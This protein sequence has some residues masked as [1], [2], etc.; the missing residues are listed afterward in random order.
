TV[1]AVTAELLGVSRRID[2]VFVQAAARAANRACAILLDEAHVISEWPEEVQEALNVTL[3]D[4]GSLGVIVSSSERR[5]VERL[6]DEGQALHMAG[7]TLG[8]PE[9]DALTWAEGLA[10]RFATLGA[11]VE[12]VTLHEMVA[13]ARHHPYCTMRLAAESALQAEQERRIKGDERPVID[14]LALAAALVV[15][16]DD[17]VWKTAIE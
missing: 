6:L 1:L 4:C 10:A 2:S 11:D 14:E 17:P 8:L 5:A 7:Y 9:I 16:R 12:P 13:A 3:R 15:V